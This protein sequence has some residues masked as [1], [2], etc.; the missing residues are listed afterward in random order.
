MLG[1]IS[2]QP[3]TTDHCF[4]I[5]ISFQNSTAPSES[6]IWKLVVCRCETLTAGLL[7]SQA[8]GVLKLHLEPI[9]WFR[10]AKLW[11]CGVT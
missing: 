3:S 7:V 1:A 2:G 6:Y 5:D 9:P 10:T 4:S 11:T 8:L